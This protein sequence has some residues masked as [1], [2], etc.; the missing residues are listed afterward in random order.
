[1]KIKMLGTAAC[2]GIPAMFCNCEYCVETRKLKG[3]NLRARTQALIDNDLLVDFNDDTYLNGQRFGIDLSAIKYFL[4]THTHCDHFSPYGFDNLN[5]AKNRTEEKVYLLGGAFVLEEF[6]RIAPRCAENLID[7]GVLE[8]VELT[9]YKKTV[10]G[11]YAI[12][13]LNAYHQKGAMV[14]II[15]KGGKTIFYC[16]DTGKMPEENFEFMKTLN[17]PFDLVVLDCT[18]GHVPADKYGGHLSLYD[19]V[20]QVKKMKDAGAVT[21]KTEIMV[22][23]FAHW[24][25]PS[26]QKMEELAG[27]F[28]YVVSYEGIEKEV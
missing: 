26:H 10:I 12:T 18:Y 13:P 15:E 1:M 20:N 19:G 25:T 28:G 4:I 9:P 14:Y 5:A 23:H 24:H 6:K 22:T 11:D 3:K 2:E 16:L 27:E 7:K 17:K 8:F 21:D